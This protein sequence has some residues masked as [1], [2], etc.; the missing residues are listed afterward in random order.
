MYG[1]RERTSTASFYF[2]SGYTLANTGQA[3]SR[4][5]VARET[6]WRYMDALRPDLRAKPSL[7]GNEARFGNPAHR[8]SNGDCEQESYM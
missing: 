7:L 3:L 4:A 1:N 6:A 5:A 8:K 2:L